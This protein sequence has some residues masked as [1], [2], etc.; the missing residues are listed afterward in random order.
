VKMG[1]K[2]EKTVFCLFSRKTGFLALA[3]RI[4][5]LALMIPASAGTVP[6]L[7]GTIAAPAWTVAA[8]AAMAAATAG[9]IP[10]SAGMVAAA[11]WTVAAT[12]GTAGGNG[13]SVGER[14]A[15]GGGVAVAKIL[16]KIFIAGTGGW[17]YYA[18]FG[19]KSQG[20]SDWW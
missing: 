19:A 20:V 8:S 14:A 11:A 18:R 6:A 7:A 3:G 4:P 1:A 13:L 10:A 9:T 5:A 17:V 15:A 12:A 16:P 2:P